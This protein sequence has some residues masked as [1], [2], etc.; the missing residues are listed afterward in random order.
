MFLT[1][2]E[3]NQLLKKG[4]K[5]DFGSKD[6]EKE[7][8]KISKRLDDI[9]ATLKINEKDS[10]KEKLNKV[11]CHVLDKLDYNYSDADDTY[12]KGLLYAPLNLKNSVCSGF[13]AYLKALSDRVGVKSFELAN[14]EHV[15]NLVKIDG[16]TYVIDATWLDGSKDIYVDIPEYNSKGEVIGYRSGTKNDLVINDIKHGKG[17]NYDW[18]LINPDDANKKDKKGYHKYLEYPTYF[19]DNLTDSAKE[20]VSVLIKDKE[21]KVSMGAL[22]GV[23]SALGG[24]RKLKSKS[25]EKTTNRTRS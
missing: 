18:Y 20:K 11:L 6:K 21:S 24:A 16:E 17:N 4:I 12:G 19:E 10:D 3:Y 25:E 2:E 9:V 5:V 22:V 1:K 15:F 23:L 13:A 14:V 7:F 8:L